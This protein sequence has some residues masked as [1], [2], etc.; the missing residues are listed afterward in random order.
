[1]TVAMTSGYDVTVAQI[2]AA[3]S[4][5]RSVTAAEGSASPIIDCDGRGHAPHDGWIDECGRV[6]RGG[7]YIP[8]D[9]TREYRTRLLVSAD[10]ADALQVALLERNDI[11]A[12]SCGAPFDGVVYAYVTARKSAADCLRR[13]APADRVLVA[14]S[15]GLP[16]GKTWKYS[17]A[18]DMAAAVRDGDLT[19]SLR[20]DLDKQMVGFYRPR[21]VAA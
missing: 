7:E 2:S 19:R 3:L 5:I 20:E 21:V 10:A 14:V 8:E 9:D 6:Y 18:R 17:Y 13:I 1:M 12:V 15:D 4:A 16:V 11:T